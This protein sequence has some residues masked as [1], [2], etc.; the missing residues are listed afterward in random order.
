MVSVR[1]GF[2]S[3]VAHLLAWPARGKRCEKRREREKEKDE[4]EDE[5]LCF[6]ALCLFW[7]LNTVR[8]S[9]FEPCQK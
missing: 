4:E 1:L 6:I 5:A 9:K 3:G 2:S 8:S 7:Q